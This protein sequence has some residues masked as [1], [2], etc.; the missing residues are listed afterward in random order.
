LIS[1]S[2][3]FEFDRPAEDVWPY[4]IALEK[5]PLWADGVVEI[6][7]L[8]PGDP[9]VGT[10][11]RVRRARAGQDYGFRGVISSL[12][13]GRS[14]TLTFRDGPHEDSRATYAVESLDGGRSRVNYTVHGNFRGPLRLL[15]P[16][17]PVIGRWVARKDLQRLQHRM[18][19]GLPP[20]SDEPTPK[21]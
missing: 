16:I 15:G 8:T 19:A 20:N 18:A 3:E 17:L 1:F 7:Q 13:D 9:G 2:Q 14:V 4:L 10:E 5:M 6:R 21:A 12:E 11:Y